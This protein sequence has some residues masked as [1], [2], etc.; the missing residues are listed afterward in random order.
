VT[1]FSQGNHLPTFSS[2]TKISVIIPTLNEEKLL[3]QFLSQFTADLTEKYQIELIISDGG[4]K[5]KTLNIANFPGVKIVEAKQNEKQNIPTGRNNG[6][7]ASSG[8]YYYFINADTRL[9]NIEKFFDLTLEEFNNTNIAAITCNVRVFPEEEKFIDKVFHKSFNT[10]IRVLNFTGIG[11][12]RG[13]CQIVRKEIF[14][15]VGGYNENLPAGEDFDLYRRIAKLG[16]IKFMKDITIYESPRRFRQRG[17]FFV[18]KD[19]TLNSLSVFFRNKA[20]S[21]NWEQVR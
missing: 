13:E 8:I 14:E 17:Y 2:K 6:A 21:E 20:V 3:P 4:S 12:G 7:K 11:M 9:Q 5:D 19:W 18:L 1:D 15:K 16:K 10:Y